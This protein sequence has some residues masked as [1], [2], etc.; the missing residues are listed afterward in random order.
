MSTLKP[1]SVLDLWAR[2]DDSGMKF[3]AAI[4][5]LNGIFMLGS[6]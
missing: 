6:L 2:K 3:G 5:Q 4:N 1:I